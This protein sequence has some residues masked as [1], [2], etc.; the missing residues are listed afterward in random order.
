QF[1]TKTVEHEIP[2]MGD[3][4]SRMTTKVWEKQTEQSHL[5]KTSKGKDLKLEPPTT[6]QFT[7]PMVKNQ[8]QPTQESALKEDG[9]GTTQKSCLRVALAA[10]LKEKEISQL[11]AVILP[12]ESGSYEDEQQQPQE[13]ASKGDGNETTGKRCQRTAPVA[14]PKEKDILQPQAEIPSSENELWEDEQQQPQKS[15]SKR[16]KGSAWKRRQRAVMKGKKISQFQTAIPL[17]EDD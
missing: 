15:T 11:Y 9:I 1:S 16:K 6:P 17:P 14:I 3:T 2:R 4:T 13:S 5:T 8:Q 7:R 10:A 12:L